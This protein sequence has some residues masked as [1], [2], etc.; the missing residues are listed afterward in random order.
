MHHK[1]STNK[2]AFKNK[3]KKEIS[4]LITKQTDDKKLAVVNDELKESL[5]E[6]ISKYLDTL[7]KPKVD[8]KFSNI[9]E[10]ITENKLTIYIKITG[11]VD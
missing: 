8:I 4:D 11:N 10:D 7:S 5:R 9:K 2:N 1:N 3:V 6:D